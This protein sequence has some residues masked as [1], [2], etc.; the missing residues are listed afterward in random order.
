VPTF[1]LKLEGGNQRFFN[2]SAGFGGTWGKFGSVTN[3]THKQGD[4]ARENTNFKLYDFS[5]K[6]AYALNDRNVLTA[7]FTFSEKI[8]FNLHGRNRS[9][10]AANPRG[11][12][13]K[14]LFLR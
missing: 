6:A 12:I 1:N 14:R 7:K 11:N 8:Q 13:S 2:G 10:F 4:G 5:N 9:E 3:F